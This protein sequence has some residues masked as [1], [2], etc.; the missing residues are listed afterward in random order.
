[1]ATRYGSESETGAIRA[2][3][4]FGPRVGCAELQSAAG[5]PVGRHLQRVVIR[6]ASKTESPYKRLEGG[7]RCQSSRVTWVRTVEIGGQG[8]GSIGRHWPSERLVLILRQPGAAKGQSI[9]RR[10]FDEV[11]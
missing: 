2:S 10:G 4:S 5:P 11:P 9:E 7:T 1:M 8:C 3:Q 6:G